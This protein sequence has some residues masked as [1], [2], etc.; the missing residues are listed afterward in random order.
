MKHVM[1]GISTARATFF[2]VETTRAVIASIS[3][4][5]APFFQKETTGTVIAMS[6]ECPKGQLL[7]RF[8]VP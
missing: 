6:F 5:R 4:V 3:K 2:R 7:T 1:V 8:G